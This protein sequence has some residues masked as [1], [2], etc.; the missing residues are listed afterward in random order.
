MDANETAILGQVLTGIGAV[1]IGGGFSFITY[2]LKKHMSDIVAWIDSEIGAN[3]LSKLTS[4]VESLITVAQKDGIVKD[5]TGSEKF[6]Q[7]LTT[8]KSEESN[9]ISKLGISDTE[10]KALI[11]KKWVSM[12]G[13]LDKAYNNATET[14]AQKVLDEANA[15]KAEAEKA[16]QEASAAKE[17]AAATLAEAQATQDKLSAAISAVQTATA[18]TATTTDA[19]TVADDATT[20]DD[21]TTDTAETTVVTPTATTNTTAVTK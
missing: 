8:V 21:K 11:E 15:K 20:T 5:L 14:Q 6:Q 13:D 7:V 9:L 16:Q 12:T 18:A 17:K 3:N 1:V 10:L 19:T 4:V 2:Y